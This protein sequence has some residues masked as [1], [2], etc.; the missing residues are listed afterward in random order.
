MKPTPPLMICDKNKN[1]NTNKKKDK[2]KTKNN[3]NYNYNDNNKI[4]MTDPVFL[5][6]IESSV[7]EILYNLTA[8][9]APQ[10]QRNLIPPMNA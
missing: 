2:N 3:Y 9:V 4:M 10:G 5:E 6:G 8:Y 7:I 1:K